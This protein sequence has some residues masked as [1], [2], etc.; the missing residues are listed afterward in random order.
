MENFTRGPQCDHGMMC[1]ATDTCLTAS[2]ISKEKEYVQNNTATDTQTLERAMNVPQCQNPA[3][4]AARIEAES[5][6]SSQK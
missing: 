5:F 2:I 4:I 3:A 1:A 6:L